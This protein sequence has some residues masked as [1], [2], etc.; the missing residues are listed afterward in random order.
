MCT[1]FPLRLWGLDDR[2]IL[3][4]NIVAAVIER[5]RKE[6]AESTTEHESVYIMEKRRGGSM[7]VLSG[8]FGS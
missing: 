6:P 7:I 1:E 8:R 4:P 3:I 2:L 5:I